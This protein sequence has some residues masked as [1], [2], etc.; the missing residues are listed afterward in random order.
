MI[1]DHLQGWLREATW[2]NDSYTQ[3]CETLVSLMK[4]AFQEGKLPVALTW[5]NMA[6]LSKMGGEYR[7]VGL[8]EV[9]CKICAYIINNQ[10]RSSITLN[11]ALHIF[12]QGRMTGTA[13]LEVNLDQYLAGLCHD[14]LFQLFLDVCKVYDC[15]ERGRCI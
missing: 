2:E 1:P 7:G 10:L 12:I 3:H 13:T 14:P 11:D 8:V 9:I 4:L 6:L 15:L 5:T